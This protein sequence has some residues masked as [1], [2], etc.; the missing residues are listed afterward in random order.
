MGRVPKEGVQGSMANN[1]TLFSAM[2]A[3][4]A[5][6]KAWIGKNL[7]NRKAW[8]A[9]PDDVAEDK[10]AVKKATVLY[11][12]YEND[13][14]FPNFDWAFEEDGFWVSSE[15]SGS[16][17]DVVAVVE[18]LLKATKSNKVFGIEWA[19][20]CSSPRV[21]EFGGGACVVTRLGAKWLSPSTWVEKTAEAAR[22]EL[23]K[24][25]RKKK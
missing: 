18:E 24:E 25:K 23:L 5:K 20:T 9:I 13:E 15:E 16:V 8:E 4:T 2:L 12:Y 21:G 11:A 3:I 1:H 22:S 6:Q 19:D 10:S 7:I 14:G 17:V